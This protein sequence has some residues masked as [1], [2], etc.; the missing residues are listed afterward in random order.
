MSANSAPCVPAKRY[1]TDRSPTLQLRPM[2]K[3]VTQF[4]CQNCQATFA[5]WQGQCDACGEW[6]TLVEEAKPI[7]SNIAAGSKRAKMAALSGST[8]S[9]YE[10]FLRPL[11]SIS[12]NSGQTARISTHFSELDRVL[13][14]GLVPGVVILIGGEPGIGKSTLLT[15]VVIELL[16]QSVTDLPRAE[17]SNSKKTK[18]AQNE[19]QTETILYVSGEESPSQISLRINRYLNTEHN[20]DTKGSQNIRQ[21]DSGQL[22]D[23][24]Q[25][26]TSTDTDTIALAIA[27]LRPK[28]VVIDSIQTLTTADLTGT[29]GSIGQLRESADRLTQVVKALSIPMFLVGH[30]TKE[31]TIAGPKVL[32][33]IVDCVLEV[34]GDRSG[35]VRLIRAIK[36]RFGA[37]DEVGV[38]QHT[39][40]G[41]S[42]VTNPSELFLEQGNH[43]VPGSA[44]V[45]VM[46]GTRP[47]LAEMQALVVSSQLAM[48]RRVG[49]GVELSR[50][51]V[52]AAVLQKHCRLPLGTHDIFL[53]A[54]GG[55]T[56]KEPSA[57]LAAAVAMASSL[58]NKKIP[59]KAVFIGEVGLLGE[60]RKVS[61]LDRRI[62]EAKRLGYSEVY[63]R[64]THP[65]LK[66]LLA[67]LGLLSA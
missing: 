9:G 21:K 48:P 22:H 52:L 38:F 64:Q 3:S 24:L 42:E 14:G 29:A 20:P 12:P 61:Y 13:G 47:L 57:D 36:N 59:S 28:L 58:T 2:A 34:S 27:K 53:N 39:E 43:Q 5:K 41:L 6:N 4:V 46:E 56:I 30:V 54:A 66:K 55:F 10:D 63:S 25:F 19:V 60:I 32:E 37:T 40:Y 23:G 7:E 45:C 26:L 65:T 49:R 50:I 67:D 16:L 1:L 51:Q 11:S 15:Q 31:G 8:S 18:S 17:I 33:H 44:T 62:K 35:Q